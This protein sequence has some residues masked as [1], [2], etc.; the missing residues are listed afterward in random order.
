MQRSERC[1]EED[2]DPALRE[3]WS[4]GET[5]IHS[6]VTGA[7][8]EP[9][10]AWGCFQMKAVTSTLRWKSQAGVHKGKSVGILQQEREQSV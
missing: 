8:I 4:S 1:G 6:R 7:L 9:N 2:T 10:P 5:F 3:C